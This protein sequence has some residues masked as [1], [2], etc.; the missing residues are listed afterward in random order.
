M[1][2][3]EFIVDPADQN[4]LLYAD[5]IFTTVAP[6]YST[7]E[8]LLG[9]TYRKLVL[10]KHDREIDLEQISSLAGSLPPTTGEPNIWDELLF[11][12][13]GLASPARS[14]QR[15]SVVF[16]QLMP[17]IPEIGRY[18]CVLGRVRNRWYPAN[19]LLQVIGAG[20][21][22]RGS[23][24]LVE[25]LG[26]ALLVS[27]NDDIFARFAAQAFGSVEPLPTPVP[28]TSMAL[29]ERE[30]RAFR[31]KPPPLI[32]NSPAERFCTDLEAVIRLKEQLTRRQW[33]VLVEAIIRLGLG[34]HLLW[35][36]HVNASYWDFV[37]RAVQSGQVPT[38]VEIEDALWYSHRSTRP[39]LEVGRDAVP[40]IKQI[41]ERYVYA[42]FGLN[43]LLHRLEDNNLSWPHNRTLGSA[44]NANLSTPEVLRQFIEYVVTNRLSIEAT[45][46]AGWLRSECTKLLDQKLGLVKCEGG[47][48]KNMLEFVRHSL[49]QI[50]TQDPEKRSY[51]QSYLLLNSRRGRGRSSPLVIQPGPAMLI[52]LVYICCQAQSDVPASLEDLRG[53]IA[54]YGLHAPAGELAGGQVGMDLKKLGLVVDSPDAAGGRLLVTP[55]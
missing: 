41:L 51:D 49:G 43:L 9:S 44:A 24:V 54:D 14:G 27:D 31:G 42:R 35:V 26:N 40:L 5:S 23:Q 25:N 21:G 16:R 20:R 32:G 48:T 10:D 2:V 15:G 46:P 6:E 18:A 1:S 53:H 55:F 47:F 28:F 37:L 52:L 30:A 12:G 34:T 39:L 7:S 45:D 36:C 8:V 17:L 29:Q 11:Q 3:N 19:L 50:E 22:Q 4:H 38:A 33:T 13:G